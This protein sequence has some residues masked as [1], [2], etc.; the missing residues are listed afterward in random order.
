MKV[1]ACVIVKD[2]EKNLPR[3]ISSMRRI[4]DELVVV[5]TGSKDRTVEIARAGGAKIFHFDWISDFSAAKNF[6]IDKATG[7]WIVF[8]DADEYFE[9]KDCPLVRE[10]IRREHRSKRT[11][12]IMLERV[13]ID[14]DG[15]RVPSP[16]GYHIRIFQNSPH[17]RYHRPIHESLE[18]DGGLPG[19][20]KYVDGLK[21]YHTG[22]SSSI[23][24]D[25]FKRNL[26][27][28]MKKHESG[29]DEPEDLSYLA[30]CCYGLGDYENAV[31]YA[32]LAIAADS[33]MIGIQNHPYL[34]LVQSLIILGRPDEEIEAA[35][36][37]AEEKFPRAP[38]YALMAGIAA[39][40]KRDYIASYECL[41]RGIGLSKESGGT[42]EVDFRATDNSEGLVQRAYLYLGKIARERGDD[43]AA[44]TFVIEGIRYDR[45]DERLIKLLSR[46][47]A[48]LADVDFISVAGEFYDTEDGGYLSRALADSGRGR[49]ALYYE[50]RSGTKVFTDHERYFFIGRYEAAAEELAYETA[51]LYALSEVA[52][53]KSSA[54]RKSGAA[55]E[56]GSLLPSKWRPEEAGE[57]LW[58]ER[59]R[60]LA[61]EV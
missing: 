55:R 21:F 47:L 11:S 29:D 54:V 15:V 60:T 52:A 5:D 42:R 20:I 45:R 31:E 39:Y 58:R 53:R 49:A 38:E 23:L 16:D 40:E 25:K 22:Y 13:D 57:T 46:L 61:L 30:D 17:L 41:T 50:R 56:E 33:G 28:L 34:I 37:L 8:L 24:K 3:W 12:G 32:R 35:I 27:I 10:L 36:S 59:V 2:E 44:I 14:V 9:D 51:A 43:E 7:D 6:A 18:N 1:S 26:K 19:I 48:E 4:A